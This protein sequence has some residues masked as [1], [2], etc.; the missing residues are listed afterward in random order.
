MQ[1]SKTVGVIDRRTCMETQDR[2]S[3]RPKGLCGNLLTF[4]IYALKI[5][6]VGVA[7]VTVGMLDFSTRNSLIV[8]YPWV[9][10]Y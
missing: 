1:V 5:R 6:G 10:S 9:E 2:R 3:Y 4:A 7:N 8:C